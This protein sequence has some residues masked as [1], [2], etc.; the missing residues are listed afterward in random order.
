MRQAPG[1]TLTPLSSPPKR[2]SERQWQ[3]TPCV[4]QH[5]H[6]SHSSAAAAAAAV[7]GC[8]AIPDALRRSGQCLKSPDSGVTCYV[9]E[10][11]ATAHACQD[12][13]AF[14]ICSCKASHR[15]RCY[16]KA[17]KVGPRWCSA[18]ALRGCHGICNVS[19]SCAGPPGSMPSH[20]RQSWVQHNIAVT[21]KHVTRCCCR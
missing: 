6:T 18:F 7:L 8:R 3:S 15:L 19:Y 11:T 2:T 17:A 14:D 1:L 9:S 20:K 10:G 12:S 21:H 13:P 4:V 16:P 5:A